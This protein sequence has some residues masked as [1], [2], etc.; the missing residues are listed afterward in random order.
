MEGMVFKYQFG[1]LGVGQAVLRKGQIAVFVAAV[2]FI[3]NNRMTE[4][5]EVDAD[6]M[7]ASGVWKDAEKR[8]WS[9][10]PAWHHYRARTDLFLPTT[11]T[12]FR[13]RGTTLSRSCGRGNS[14]RWHVAEESFFDKKFGLGGGAVGADAIF[15]SH[16][17]AFVLSQRRV[18]DAM[19]F[20]DVSVDDGE[21]FFLDEA[22]FQGFSK[23]A[24]GLR[25]FRD[26]DHA[27]GFAVEAVD[28]I[29]FRVRGLRAGGQIQT[30][31]ADEA[32]HLAVLGGMTDQAGG[33]V[34]HEQVCVFKNDLK[35]VFHNLSLDK[36]GVS[37]APVKEKLHK[38]LPV[39]FIVV[40]A[41]SRDPKLM[42]PNFSAVYAF[43]FC[44]GV[45]F[46]KRISWWLPLLVIMVTDIGLNF[47][48]QHE[49]PDDN[50]WSAANLANLG[51]NYAAYA[52]LIFLGRCFKPASPFAALLGA[53]IFGAVLF[54]LIT[55]TA[56][57]LFNPFHNPEYSKNLAGWILALTKGV[58]GWPTTLEFFRNT[59]ISTG[60]FTAL[61]V[62]SEK[63]SAPSE[64][65]ADKL[66]GASDETETEPEEAEA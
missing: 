59:F 49:Y 7:F 61:F 66:A 25:I 51:F 23:F 32:G 31:A 6:L 48:Y 44:A 9:R 63:L 50:V 5:G 13:C 28:H 42:P 16:D 29:G 24:G 60:L 1:A 20:T 8:E 15:Y 57:W 33:F 3:A 64:S 22:V 19:I 34:D 40:L 54:Y 35:K 18:D 46:S 37:F 12:R 30:G 55:N 26:Q 43:V 56:S 45:Y 11:L 53:G 58:S 47:Y 39:L 41:V 21:V 27:A 36:A 65:P 52:G 10:T 4:M 62:G 2:E 38:L 17:A 14:G